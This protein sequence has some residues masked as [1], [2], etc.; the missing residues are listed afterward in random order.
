M[1]AAVL[2]S[3]GLAEPLRFV[4]SMLCVL[5]VLLLA[6]QRMLLKCSRVISEMF[7]EFSE[8]RWPAEKVHSR[9][10]VFSACYKGSVF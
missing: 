8:S 3:A 1:S 4:S 5:F 2:G 10:K 9:Q 7:D 6:D